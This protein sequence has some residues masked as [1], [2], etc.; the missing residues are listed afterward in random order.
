VNSQALWYLSRG[1][2]LVTLLLVTA[3]VVLG[4]LNSGRLA[5]EQ[6]PRFAVAAVHRNISLLSLVFLVIH[7]TTAIIDPYAGI[8]WLDAVI[9]FASSYRTFWLGLGTL[10]AEVMIAMIITSL[11]RPR[12]NY[13]LWRGVHWAAYAMWPIAVIHGLGTGTPDNHVGWV[14]VFYGVCTLAVI[15]ALA[16]RLSTSHPDTEARNGETSDTTSVAGQANRRLR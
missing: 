11:L 6:W 4:M 9:P 16:W 2:G 15:I 3:S 14:L 8:H 10:A 13:R 5:T 1:T 7:V 12:I